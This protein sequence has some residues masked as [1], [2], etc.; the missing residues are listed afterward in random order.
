MATTFFV[1]LVALLA[2]PHASLAVTP[3]GVGTGALLGGDLTDP[4]N[5]INDSRTYGQNFDWIDAGASSE[6]WFTPADG[7]EAAF[8]AFDNKVGGGEAKWCCDAAPQNVWVRFDRAYQLTHFTIASGNDVEG[9]D[10]TVW[11]IEGS[12]DGISWTPIFTYNNPGVTPFTAR[13]QVLLYEAA[14][15]FQPPGFYSYFRYRV[16]Q[17]NGASMHQI[18]ELELFGTPLES[19]AAYDPALGAPA[20]AEVGQTCDSGTLLDGRGTRGPEPNYPNTIDGCA[21]GN[22]GTYHYDESNDRLVIRTLDGSPLAEGATVE[23]T[24]TVW[25]WTIPSD[26]TLELYHTADVANPSWTL[27]GTFQ[28]DAVGARTISTQYTLPSGSLQALRARFRFLGT[29]GS[30]SGGSYTD[31]DDLVFAVANAATF[32]PNYGVPTCATTGEA[33]DSGTLLERSGSMSPPESNQPNTFDAVADGLYNTSYG[34]AE[35]IER[36]VVSGGL[37]QG[38]TVRVD[39]D[40]HAWF[41]G[42]ANFVALYQTGAGDDPL[43]SLSLVGVLYPPVGGFQTLSAQYTLPPGSLHRLRALVQYTPECPGAPGTCM[44]AGGFYDMDDLIFAV[45]DV[46]NDNCPNVPNPGQEDSD[47]DGI[48][49]ACE[50]PLCIDDPSITCADPF[51]CNP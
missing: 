35:S 41:D 26:D 50:H 42:T 47:L 36:I 7:L 5:D 11:Y 10:P 8:D 40:L 49:D 29:P 31:V 13:Q 4:G 6:P 48:G 17:T 27:I 3:L 22:S 34:A 19:M 51:L 45:A 14:V 9:R 2:L 38:S 32:D 21:D 39:V 23:V 33:C 24:A 18:G 16:A 37:H 30:C 44:G 25:A 28:P 46:E 1:L 20:C 43:A 15:D 12:N